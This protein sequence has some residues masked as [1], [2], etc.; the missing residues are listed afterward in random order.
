MA[1]YTLGKRR[2]QRRHLISISHPRAP[3]LFQTVRAERKALSSWKDYMPEKLH[4]FLMATHGCSPAAVPSTL[5]SGKCVRANRRRKRQRGEKNTRREEKGREG[6][7]HDACHVRNLS[8]TAALSLLPLLRLRALG[9]IFQRTGKCSRYREKPPAR[10]CTITYDDIRGRKQ[11]VARSR[12]L[13]ELEMVSLRWR[14][15][16][17]SP[18]DVRRSIF[19]NRKRAS[20]LS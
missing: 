4:T 11:A 9:V 14:M 12:R 18:D 7:F 2:R 10:R 17:D 20:T 15:S 6:T 8:S 13:R 5:R 19:R 16:R 1:R 3:F